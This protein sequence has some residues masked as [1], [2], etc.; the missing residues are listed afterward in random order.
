MEPDEQYLR[1]HE[2]AAHTKL[3]GLLPPEPVQEF[4]ALGEFVADFYLEESKI[5]IMILDE[6]HDHTDSYHLE[7]NFADE[8]EKN[9]LR[10]VFIEE[11][12]I[13]QDPERVVER[14][15]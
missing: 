10:P 1:M 12:E 8:A 5:I 6:T 2:S 4:Y 14:L 7:K 11:T 3:R 15:N 13:F 9:N